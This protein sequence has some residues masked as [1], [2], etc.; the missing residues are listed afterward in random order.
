M[1][2]RGYKPPHIHRQCMD[3]RAEVVAEGGIDEGRRDS[4]P[5]EGA[6]A[7]GLSLLRHV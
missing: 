4:R 6:A 7:A 2:K 3:K 5:D 1:G